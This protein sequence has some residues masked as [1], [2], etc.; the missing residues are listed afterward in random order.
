MEETGLKVIRT[1]KNAEAA[2]LENVE[3][4]KLRVAAYCRVSTLN[5]AQEESFETQKAAYE[6]LIDSNPGLE[7][8]G[9][10]ADRGISGGS[11]KKRK[12]F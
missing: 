2:D 3:G 1:V 6:T 8:A 7:L 5:E 11:I 10:Y 4:K 9:I 12:Q